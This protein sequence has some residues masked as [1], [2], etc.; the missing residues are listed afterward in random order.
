MVHELPARMARLALALLILAFVPAAAGAQDQS[1]AFDQAQE[2]EI[3]DIVR[4]YLLENPEV[5]IEAINVYRDRQRVAAEERQQQAVKQWESALASD[6][7]AP[8]LGNPEG[9][10]TIVEFFDYNCGYCKSVA[11]GVRGAIAKDSGIRLVM[12]EFPILGPES[13]FA[14]RAALAA[15]KQ[16]R[17]EDFHF[18]LMTAQGR[19]S[20]DLVMNI[21]REL[22][23]D[24][25]K[26]RQDMEKPG[27]DAALRR[28]FELAEGLEISGTPAFVIGS[29]V[30]PGA[31]DIETLHRIVAETRAGAS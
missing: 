3:R 4:E 8:I 10:V 9:D 17:Y 22:D 31:L 18:N 1:P 14:A 13:Q 5:L 27:V 26:L 30:F 11:E 25:D 29:Q 2:Q 12:K 19:V 6:P 7:D 24:L 20:E 21:A 23:L 15:A 28:N 16:G